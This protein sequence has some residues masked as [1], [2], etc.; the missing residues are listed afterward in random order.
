MEHL[1]SICMGIALAAC[2]GFRV[3]VPLLVASIGTKFGIIPAHSGFEW[4][5]TWTAM[6]IFGTAS[7]LE[8]GAYYVPVVDHFL[9][10]LTTPL[11]MIAGTALASSFFTD[12]FEGIPALKWVLGV[13]VGGG[14]AGM[15]QAGTAMARVGSTTTT[16]GLGN[17]I[18]STIENVMSIFFSALSLLIPIIVGIVFVFAF[19]LIGWL[20]IR[21]FSKKQTLKTA[22]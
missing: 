18:L 4:L 15:V 5:G 16:A 6:S 22:L 11:S 9:D 7:I 20:L 21:K 13:I 10:T 1:L 14:S 12:F 8:I 19:L 2:C 3:F 17:P